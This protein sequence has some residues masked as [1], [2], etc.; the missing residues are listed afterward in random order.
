VWWPLTEK[1]AYYPACFA[2]HLPRFVMNSKVGFAKFVDQFYYLSD[3]Q[4]VIVRISVSFGNI[5][6]H[7]FLS[8]PH[9]HRWIS[10]FMLETKSY[11]LSSCKEVKFCHRKQNTSFHN[12]NYSLDG[13]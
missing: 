7:P 9:H 3:G 5:M 11:F 4:I 1:I 2:L 10:C 8:L 13:S 12:K 6:G